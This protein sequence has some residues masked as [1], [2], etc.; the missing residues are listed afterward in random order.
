MKTRRALQII[1]GV[2]SLLVVLCLAVVAA[3]GALAALFPDMSAAVSEIYKKVMNG[4]DIVAEAF[5]IPAY[6]FLVPLLALGLPS[7]LLLLAAILLFL[8]DKGKQGKYVAGNVL[9]LIGIAILT[10]F[11]VVFAKDIVFEFDKT[12]VTP[13]SYA[14]IVR[15]S[16]AGL[17]ALF[18]IFVGSALGVKPK[19]VVATESVLEEES[20]ETKAEENEN[21][22]TY[23]TVAPTSEQQAT[24]E[25]T[26]SEYVPGNAS[27][28]EVTDGVYG[29]K[30]SSSQNVMDKINKAHMFYQMGAITEEE[31]I[32][33]VSMY[34]K[35]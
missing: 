17:L 35:K 4:F 9:A 28:S 20:T 22:A 2:L 32:K 27:V 24:Q 31:Y 21:S 26:A 5:S 14:W 29:K 16:A 13:L 30:E 33:L 34:L 23:E 6:T 18:V 15:L 10:L 12:A 19:N 8:R 3:C 1:V 7:L 11:A 25:Q